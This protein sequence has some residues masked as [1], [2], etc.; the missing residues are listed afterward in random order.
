MHAA[1][2][3][4]VIA[5]LVSM[6]SAVT[7]WRLG[8][9]SQRITTYRSATDLVLEVDRVFI[10]HPQLRPYF[11]EDTVCP[12][13]HLDKNLVD[14]VAEL[15]LDVLECI[16]DSRDTY[17]S[18]D[19]DSWAQYIREVF[20][21]SPAIRDAYSA[22]EGWYPTLDLLFKEEPPAPVQASVQARGLRLLRW[23]R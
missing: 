2:T 5:L 13:G 4:S 20:A 8:E 1:E 15:Q 16:W 7:A 14:A 10:D 18:V 23:S 3:I 9:Q 11:Y 12:A 6:A 19:R 21:A 22:N 17:T